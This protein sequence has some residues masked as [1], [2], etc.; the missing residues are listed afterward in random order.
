MPLAFTN[1]RIVTPLEVIEAGAVLVED[2]RIVRVGPAAPAPPGYDVIELQGRTLAPGFIDLHVHGGGGFSLMAGDPE[3][4]RSFAR[5][6]VSKGVTS[7][8]ITSI[9]APREHLMT[10]LRSC[11]PLIRSVGSARAD[12]WSGA[13]PLGF[14][15]EGPFINP[16]RA[17][18][19]P[20][21]S[22]R[23]PDVREMNEYLEAA[24]GELRLVTLAPELPGADGLIDAVLRAGAAPSLGH[25]DA[26]YEEARRAF[27]RGVRH[28][29]HAF[30]A[31][32]PFHQRDPGCLAAALNAP[33]VTVELIADG[34]HVHPGAMELLMRSKGPERTALVSD[35]MPFAGLGDGGFEVEGQRI[36]VEGGRAARHDGMLAGSAVM[37]DRMVSN[38]ARRLPLR[39]EEA[40]RMATLSPATVLGVSDRKGRIAAGADA[41]LVVLDEAL[42][43]V[44]TFV[45]GERVFSRA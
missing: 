1:A 13:Q 5:W 3:E 42:D 29:T 44:M 25:S 15:L 35:G 36:V 4:V 14:N 39:L 43:V 9:A 31:L 2:G 23:M 24:A 28:V 41:D 37:L 21:E 18:A 45:R 7:F 8:L 12:E 38:V 10:L 32:R 30:N 33:D 22:I 16:A 26:T 11:L 34:V 20:R 40:V 27:E 6:A 19:Q 17:G